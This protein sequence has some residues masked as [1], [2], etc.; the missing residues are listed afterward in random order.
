MRSRK[1]GAVAIDRLAQRR[2][3][4]PHAAN[5]SSHRKSEKGKYWARRSPRE[6]TTRLRLARARECRRYGHPETWF[7]ANRPDLAYSTGAGKPGPY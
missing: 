3:R 1:P 2:P 4:P 5:R 7:A 6:L